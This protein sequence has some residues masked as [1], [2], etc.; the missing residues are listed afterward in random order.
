MKRFNHLAKV[1]L[2]ALLA[3][4]GTLSLSA[5]HKRMPERAPLQ[6]TGQTSEKAYEVFT[7]FYK[8]QRHNDA[9]ALATNPGPVKLR[10]VPSANARK[11][12]RTAQEPVGSMY[13]L[14]PMHSQ[15]E[16]YDAA[17]FGKMDPQSLAITKMYNGMEYSFGEDYYFM[18]G[19]MRN[20]ILYIPKY[21]EDTVTREITVY[22][23]AVDI[24]TGNVLESVIFGAADTALNAF[25]NSLTYD[26]DHDLFYGLCLNIST[27]TPGSL[28]VIDPKE[29]V[30]TPKLLS[31]L[32]SNE[33][34]TMCNIVYNPMDQNLYGLKDNGTLNMVDMSD[35]AWPETIPVQQYDDFNEYFCYPVRLTTNAMCY[36]PYDHAFFFVYRDEFEEKMKLIGID[37]ETYE[38]FEV[39]A[40]TPLGF[41]ASIMCD[42]PFAP[43]NA[44]D[45]MAAPT[46]AFDKA[47][48]EGTY[49]VSAPAYTFAGVAILGDVT[50]HVELDDA[51]LESFT[52][53]AG[54]KAT[55]PISTTHGPHTLKAY[56]STDG[57]TGP[58]GIL[59]FFTGYDNPQP[60][61]NLQLEGNTLT[62]NAPEEIGQHNGYVDLTD[63]TYDVYFNSEKINLQPITETKFT[64]AQ[65]DVM[66]RKA[67]TVTATSSGMTSLHS[68]PLSR[69]VGEA[70]PIP[71]Y[72]QPATEAE[73]TL[74]E[75]YNAD[76]DYNVFKFYP[77]KDDTPA[78]YAIKTALG[79]Q[80]PND[81]L[82]I[83][84]VAIED[85]NALYELTFNYSNAYN[86]ERH[87]DN[88]EVYIGTAPVDTKMIRQ[89]YT[90]S[91]RI[92]P[93]TTAITVRFA[94]EQPGEYYFGFHADGPAEASNYRGVRLSDF[95]IKKADNSSANVPGSAQNV[96]FEADPTGALSVDINFTAPVNDVLGR[97][98]PKGTDITVTAESGDYKQSTTL[99]S[100]A[101]GKITLSVN[102]DGLADIYITCSSSEGEGLREYYS[103][104]VGLD[105]PTPPTNVKAIIDDDN[106]GMT[107]TWDAPTTGAHGGYINV[108]DLTYDI[109]TGSSIGAYHKIGTAD[110][111]SYHFTVEPSTQYWYHVGPVAVNEMGT[112]TNGE[113]IFETLGN[114]YSLPMLESW[115]PAGFDYQRWGYTST[116]EYSNSRADNLSSTMGLGMGDPSFS[117]GGGMYIGN[118]GYG[119]T[120]YELTAPRLSTL[121]NKKVAFT[122]R[123][124]DYINA[125]TTEIWIQSNTDQEFKKISEVKLNRKGEWVD[126]E[127]ELPA[128][129][130]DKPWIQINLRGTLLANQ[131]VLFD[132]YKINQII[133]HD[134]TAA[135]VEGETHAVA[136]ESYEYVAKITN[137]GI[138]AG[139]T[140]FKVDVLGDGEVLE[141]VTATTGRVAESETYEYVVPITMK[142][143]WLKYDKLEIAATITDADDENDSNNTTSLTFSLQPNSLPIVDQPT[144]ERDG[145]DVVLTWPAPDASYGSPEGFEVMEP[146]KHDELLGFWTNVDLDG[147]NV[148]GIQNLFDDLTPCGWMVWNA[149][150]LGTMNDPRLSPHTGKQML[151]A[152][153]VDYE[154]DETITEPIKSFDWLIS[155][156]IVPG[157]EISFWLNTFSQ[158]YTETI[159]IWVSDTDNVI[160][161]DNIEYVEDASGNKRPRKCGSFR[162]VQN[163]SK[164]GVDTWEHCTV[165]PK[166][167][168]NAKYFAIVYG[169]IGMF[170]ASIDDLAFE[171]A[172]TYERNIDS[173]E[174]MRQLNDSE[175]EV[176]ATGVKGLTLRDTNDALNSTY[177][178]RAVV[179][180]DNGTLFRAPYSLPVSING[181]SVSTLGANASVSAGKG[182]VV[183]TGLSGKH[184]DLYD[185]A[186]RHIASAD[187]IS[188]LQTIPAEAG[189]VMV[190][191][192]GKRTKLMVK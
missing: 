71:Y 123:T 122:I 127:V 5:E 99:K 162:W 125:G 32:G 187:I 52:I 124:W 37:A 88:L 143:D 45:R 40:I 105:T 20:G 53:K 94:V 85:A 163:F 129:Y 8:T 33:G 19:A 60:P 111:Y 24:A 190:Q 18:T 16:G 128:E 185:A 26:P 36:S 189:V 164:S 121:G 77:A 30:W 81:W 112:S 46:V 7:S 97:P 134:F 67:I 101:D 103:H 34:D 157:S 150:Q 148:F 29:A 132:T 140:S 175:P 78:Y 61:T 86:N 44:P 70:F 6:R 161:P 138:E 31:N 51:P 9:T 145:A 141:T 167:L 65:P 49:T 133:D 139:I 12:M 147:G 87:R 168:V 156:E 79:Y 172:R 154:G 1:C 4:T 177:W 42:D 135:S 176:I 59:T 56:A 142:K 64:F 47:S 21:T 149:E 22:W 130:C 55:R 110:G 41:I 151:V 96:K 158:D 159:E 2:A 57:V 160:D 10:S 102:E 92:T 107:I 13:C 173:Y 191:I 11:I 27:G 58:A 93:Q 165:D 115:N 183:F 114:L 174:V 119:P 106:L 74:F 80:V 90:H 75:T 186:G 17:Y 104:Y 83:P 76:D 72:I 68:T 166:H 153:S 126:W 100:G 35:P 28:V 155:P 38:A 50:I 15:A 146:F 113:F 54:E 84:A 182:C 89:I 131:N 91:D 171:P 23:Q 109:Y 39:G 3:F 180:N 63:V 82:F 73:A 179:A 178:V 192:E 66:Q 14:V 144:A 170:G 137:S 118:I 95:A 48:L 116:G 25:C 169:S 43:D 120:R 117:R 188:D 108:E 136:G 184:A 98:L 152:R 181:S 69:A 62:W